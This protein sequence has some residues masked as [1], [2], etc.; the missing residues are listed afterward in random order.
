MYGSDFPNIPY[1]W[2]RESKWLRDSHLGA[3]ELEM[4]LNNNAAEFFG[5]DPRGERLADDRTR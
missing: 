5:L 3:D 2:D 1:A 4:I